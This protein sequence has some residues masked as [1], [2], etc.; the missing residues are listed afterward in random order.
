M[1]VTLPALDA[2]F[3]AAEDRLDSGIEHLATGGDPDLTAIKEYYLGVYRIAHELP[4][5]LEALNTSVS[6][7]NDLKRLPLPAYCTLDHITSVSFSVDLAYN[8]LTT[9]KKEL[10]LM[11]THIA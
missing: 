6:L 8:Q 2:R 7:L 3:K 10:D 9:L 11:A 5:L 4:A 1:E